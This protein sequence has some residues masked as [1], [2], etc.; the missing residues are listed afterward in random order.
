[1]R[2]TVSSAKGTPSLYLWVLQHLHRPAQVEAAE[3]LEYFFTR[4]L[5]T[6]TLAET[7]ATFTN[8]NMSATRINFIPMGKELA[9]AA[10]TTNKVVRRREDAVLTN[11]IVHHRITPQKFASHHDGIRHWH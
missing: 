7:T 5:R 3:K 9:T 6:S 8:Q 1:M 2:S 4:D 11:P 10:L